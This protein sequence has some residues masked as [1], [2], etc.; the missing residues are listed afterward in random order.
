MDRNGNVATSAACAANLYAYTSGLAESSFEAWSNLS[1]NQ[2][3]Q[4]RHGPAGPSMG[5]ASQLFCDSES[6]A[7]MNAETN[8]DDMRGFSSVHAMMK[9]AA[10]L[11]HSQPHAAP[12]GKQQPAT[13]ASEQP[14]VFVVPSS[15]ARGP[16]PRPRHARRQPWADACAGSGFW[17]G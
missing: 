4:K 2:I 13:D 17:C 5:D 14:R 9:L 16:F 1:K 6:R 15:Q 3:C 10:A 7:V 11:N 12:F 8:E